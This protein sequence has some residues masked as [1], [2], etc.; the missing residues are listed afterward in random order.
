MAKT[1]LVVDD[2]VSIRQMVSFTLTEAG[3]EILQGSNGQEGL[4][5]LNGQH[6]DL[7]VTDLNMPIMDGFDLIR[8]ARAR[9]PYRFTPILVLTTE[10]KDSRK[11]EGKQAG[12]TGWIVKPFNPQQLKQV[13]AKVV[14]A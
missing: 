13:V 14:P 12:A 11:Q 8:Q 7:I 4:G 5:H 6:V 9:A 10:S 1:A 2:S 3:F